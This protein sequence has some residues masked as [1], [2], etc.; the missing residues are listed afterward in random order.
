MNGGVQDAAKGDRIMTTQTIRR[1]LIIGAG[2]GGPVLGMWLRRLGID[3]AIA[4]ARPEPSLGEGAFLGVA[5]NG[6]HVLDELGIAAAIAGRGVPCAA[7]RFR[8]AADRAIGFIDRRQ[9]AERY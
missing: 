3:V 5:P 1:V 4:E 7:F 9:D 6:M 2:V 8:N